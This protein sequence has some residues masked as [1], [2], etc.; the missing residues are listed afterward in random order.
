MKKLFMALVV[1]VLV[2]VPAVTQAVVIN[3]D[4]I[5]GG[6]STRSWSGD[7][8]LAQ[9]VVFSTDGNF[10][11][12]FDAAYTNTQPTFVY[13]RSSFSRADKQVIAIFSSLTDFVSFYLA[14]ND[15]GSGAS[16]KA[17][18][19]DSANALL[20]N[21]TGVTNDEILI[22]F[23]FPGIKK[24]VFTPS[25]DYEGIDTL[26]FNAAV[27]EPAIM[28]LLGSGLLGL[29]GFVRRKLKK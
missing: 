26:T 2:F 25:S 22:S 19:F 7:R 10:L 14:D 18:V 4:D 16:W 17:E 5:P 11:G 20:A 15:I 6:P 29:A 13:G 24:L 12:A 3:F 1:I 28:V 21:Q 9:G 27:P 23:N 8:Y